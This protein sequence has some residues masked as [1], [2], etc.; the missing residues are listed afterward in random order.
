MSRPITV[1]QLQVIQDDAGWIYVTTLCGCAW[2]T[3]DGEDT[4][5]ATMTSALAH[6]GGETACATLPGFVTL[7]HVGERSSRVPQF[8]HLN[9]AHN[10]GDSDG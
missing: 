1:A 10:S 5:G 2:K 4:L 9:P 7:A 6:A 3:V 8:R